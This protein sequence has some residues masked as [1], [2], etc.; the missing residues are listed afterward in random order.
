MFG[1]TIND[2]RNNVL[3]VSLQAAA[4]SLVQFFVL[5][6]DSHAGTVAGTVRALC[7]H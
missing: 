5:H 1:I 7:G 6:K 4:V 2:K 3:C